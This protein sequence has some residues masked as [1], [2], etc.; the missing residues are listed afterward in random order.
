MNVNTIRNRFAATLGSLLA[1][2]ALTACASNGGTAD[3]AATAGPTDATVVYHTDYPVYGNVDSLYKRADLVVEVVVR[4]APAVR[5]MYP[6]RKVNGPRVNDPKVNPRAGTAAQPT[7]DPLITTV[8]RAKLTRVHKGSAKVGD[9]VEVKQL[10]GRY[11]GITYHAEGTTMLRQ[12][13]SYLLF[14]AVFPD[15]PASL[16]NPEQG[17]YPLDGRGR[18]TRLG[19]NPVTVSAADLSRLS[20]AR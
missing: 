16:L 18:P 6:N 3:R 12:G 9:T 4:D 20:T 8:F 2:F 15:A 19:A 17:Q 5:Q 11:G 10:G 7:G 13:R 1:I 14:L